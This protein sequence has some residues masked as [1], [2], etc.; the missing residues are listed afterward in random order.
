MKE[1]EIRNAMGEYLVPKKESFSIKDIQA[2]N[3]IREELVKNNYF[4]IL[5]RLEPYS[6]EKIG[7]YE[8]EKLREDLLER[9]AKCKESNKL[10]VVRLDEV[11]ESKYTAEPRRKE[12]EERIAS[13]QLTSNGLFD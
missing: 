2:I 13:G 5:S 7:S 9:A 4:R 6:F 10:S 3:R 11:G 12:L 1:Q 8:D